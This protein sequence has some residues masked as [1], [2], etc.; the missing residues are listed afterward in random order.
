MGWEGE[1][2][3][4]QS[5]EYSTEQPGAGRKKSGLVLGS[6]LRLKPSWIPTKSDAEP[7]PYNPEQ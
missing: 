7:S 6:S 5:E 3:S 2:A 4:L 1:K